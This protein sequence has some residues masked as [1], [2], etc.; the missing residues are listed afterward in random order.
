MTKYLTE[1]EH[2]AL[3]EQIAAGQSSIS[4]PK[5]VSRQFFTHVSNAS[6]RGTLGESIRLRKLIIYGGILVPVALMLAT[7]A[8]ILVLFGWGAAIGI[9]L[10]GAFWVIV[11][12]L[13]GDRGSWIHDAVALILGISLASLIPREYGIPLTLF[14]VSLTLYRLN[15]LLAQVWLERLVI[16]SFAAYD[17]LVEHVRVSEPKEPDA[18]QV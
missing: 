15:Y 17:M 4:I 3:R 9:P 11:A 1:P 13:A 8:A 14:T 6:V 10:A 2:A 12:G 7:L 18:P 16:R 5:A